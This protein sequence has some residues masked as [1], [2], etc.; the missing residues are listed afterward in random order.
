MP[1]HS[2]SGVGSSRWGASDGPYSPLPPLPLPLPEEP[3]LPDPAAPELEP[4]APDPDPEP[5]PAE[6]EP[7]PPPAPQSFCDQ[8]A[9]LGFRFLQ[10]A[11]LF[12]SAEFFLPLVPVVLES[13]CPK[14]CCPR[15]F[16]EAPKKMPPRRAAMLH[17]D[18]H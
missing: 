12:F 13:C 2:G 7:L 11:R 9:S 6:A 1:V 4:L 17:L 15:S 14:R 3:D 8:A 18:H 16:Y 10:A 5:A